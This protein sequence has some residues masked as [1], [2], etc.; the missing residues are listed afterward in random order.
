MCLAYREREDISAKS[1]LDA[2]KLKVD[3]KI[4]TDKQV[5][6]IK[7]AASYPGV[8][9]IFVNPAIKKALC[10]R[11]GKDRAWLGKVRPLWGHDYH[12]HIRIGCTNSGCESQ[13]AV[14]GDDGCGKEVDNWLKLDRQF[15][16]EAAAQARREGCRCERSAHGHDEPAARRVQDGAR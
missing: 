6:L 4:F 13:P 16:Q 2:T 8:E 1:M 5:A 9:R 12:F 15:A 10:E 7:R 3:P 14:H 11:A